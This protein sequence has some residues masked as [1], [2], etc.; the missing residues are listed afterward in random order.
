MTPQ[1]GFDRPERAYHPLDCKR[2]SDGQN[3]HVDPK[4]SNTMI[5]EVFINIF[6][7]GGGQVEIQHYEIKE[8]PKCEIVSTFNH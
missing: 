5:V 3:G 7:G 8:M 6:L 1:P 2:T 4:P